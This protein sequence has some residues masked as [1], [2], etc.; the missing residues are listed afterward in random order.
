MRA[1]DPAA[2]RD[3]L[4]QVALGSSAAMRTL[5]ERCAGRAWAVTLRIL[6]SRS[7]AEEVLQETFLE[8]WRR[9]REFDPDRG[10]VETWVMMI[11]RTR[12]IDRKRTLSTMARVAEEAGTQPPPVSATPAGPFESAEQGQARAR[13]S[14]ALRE[15]PREQRQ[16]VELAY[17]EGLSQREIA[18]R[19]GDPLGTVK[20]RTRLALEKLASRLGEA[21]QDL[22]KQ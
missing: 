9:A 21:R 18:E 20:T 2:D 16:V 5:Y 10:G 19:T 6:G 4:Q 8:V 3:L 22:G 12:A 15:L 11:A 14:V 13:V 1:S 7:D 17:F